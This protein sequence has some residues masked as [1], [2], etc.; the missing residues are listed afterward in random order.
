[1]RSRWKGVEN[2]VKILV[3]V[4]KLVAAAEPSFVRYEIMPLP[5]AIK[6]YVPLLYN[7]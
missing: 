4:S 7:V 3:R 5:P 2:D 6:L 1:M